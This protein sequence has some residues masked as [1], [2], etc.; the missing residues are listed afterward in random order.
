MAYE[1]IDHDRETYDRNRIDDTVFAARKSGL[2]AYLLWFFLGGFGMHNFYLSRPRAGAL[3]MIGTLFIYCTYASDDQWWQLTGL[4]V[5]I[6]VGVSLFLDMFKIPTY[7]VD[8]SERLRERL[9][10]EMTDWRAI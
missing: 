6:P 2:I 1:T 5:G 10:D 7:V 9:K 4:V 3:Q 8:C